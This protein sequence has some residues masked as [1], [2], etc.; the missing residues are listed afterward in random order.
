MVQHLVIWA[1]E[2]VE[3]CALRDTAWLLRVVLCSLVV[4]LVKVTRSHD[5]TILHI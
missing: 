5:H 3:Y 1:V 2:M 4:R